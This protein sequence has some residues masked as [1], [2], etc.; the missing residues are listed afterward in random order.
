MV[1]EEFTKYVV[2]QT[3]RLT[4]LSSYLPARSSSEKVTGVPHH[5]NSYERLSVLKGVLGE[6]ATKSSRVCT[7]LLRRS[8]GGELL[9]RGYLVSKIKE[10][11]I[12]FPEISWHT[13]LAGGADGPVTGAQLDCLAHWIRFAKQ[14]NKYPG[15]LS[16]FSAFEYLLNRQLVQDAE[17]QQALNIGLKHDFCTSKTSPQSFYWHTFH[18]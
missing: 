9:L 2:S 12:R 8:K 16:A 15:R 5:S 13:T 14:L 6:S 18:W 7:E 10:Q 17:S 3:R 11:S 1:F 4:I